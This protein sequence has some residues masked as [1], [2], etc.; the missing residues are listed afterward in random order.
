[1]SSWQA[2][3]EVWLIKPGIIR[4]MDY[5]REE[6]TEH[7]IAKA[8]RSPWRRIAYSTAARFQ[9]KEPIW[10]AKLYNVARL[11]VVRRMPLP[12]KKKPEKK[13]G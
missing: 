4:V 6:F 9:A 11:I 1:M 12:D 13:K 5:G 7:K 3:N 2:G 10:P 8:I